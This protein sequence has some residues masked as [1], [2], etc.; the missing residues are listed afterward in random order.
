MSERARGWVMVVAGLL[1]MGLN[2]VEVADR[3]SSTWNFLTIAVGAFLLF[4]GFTVIAKPPA[5]PAS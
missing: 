4:Y 3:G 1:V 2:V 5:P